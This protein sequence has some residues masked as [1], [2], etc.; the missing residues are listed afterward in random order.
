MKEYLLKVVAA[1]RLRKK[2]FGVI[3]STMSM[4]HGVSAALYF[5]WKG[6]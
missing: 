2:E 6:G 4:L 1:L 3:I 5:F